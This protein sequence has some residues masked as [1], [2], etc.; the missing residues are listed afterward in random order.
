MNKPTSSPHKSTEDP[1]DPKHYTFRATTTVRSVES[2]SPYTSS[3]PNADYVFEYDNG[4]PVTLQPE[5][6][7][8]IEKKKKKSDCRKGDFYCSSKTC[9]T[10]PMVCDG[11]KVS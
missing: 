5:N 4:E 11:H 6:I 2:W 10:K 7:I 9:V 1:D 8:Q 3:D